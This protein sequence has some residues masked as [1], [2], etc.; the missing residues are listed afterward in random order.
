M[1]CYKLVSLVE[2]KGI[3]GGMARLEADGGLKVQAAVRAARHSVKY[4]SKHV[5]SN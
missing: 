1:R 4:K 2:L 5:T 3:F